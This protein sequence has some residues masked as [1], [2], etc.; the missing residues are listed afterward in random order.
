MLSFLPPE[1]SKLLGINGPKRTLT[2]FHL[3][4][5]SCA[6]I[7]LLNCSERQVLFAL[8]VIEKYCS[9]AYCSSHKKYLALFLC[10]LF[11]VLCK[12]SCT[13]CFERKLAIS[14]LFRLN[15]SL[16]KKEKLRA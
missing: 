2:V 12:S 15:I 3:N 13:I 5:N 1:G 6:A 10:P 4:S 11:F 8:L 9:C 7:V 14:F 16:N